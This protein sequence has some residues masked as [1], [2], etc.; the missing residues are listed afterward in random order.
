MNK[1]LTISLILI[2]A[3]TACVASLMIGCSPDSGNQESQAGQTTTAETLGVAYPTLML[4]EDYLK[5]SPQLQQAYYETFPSPELYMEWFNAAVQ[6]YNQAESGEAAQE[7][8]GNEGQITQP[9]QKQ[10][11]TG[12]GEQTPQPKPGTD[13]TVAD[14]Q[15]SQ[16]QVESVPSQPEQTVQ[17]E[18]QEETSEGKEGTML[19]GVGSIVTEVPPSPLE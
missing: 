13:A 18:N 9:T 19:E 3:L 1:R 15:P 12:S 10:E 11:G 4:Y 2:I 14:T 16:T 5:L 8:A 7:V 17:T 6:A